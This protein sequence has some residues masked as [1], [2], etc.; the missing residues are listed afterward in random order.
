MAYEIGIGVIGMGWMGMVH[1]RSY[2]MVADRFADSGIQARL[3]ICADDVEDRAQKAKA[4]LGFAHYT[5]DWRQVIEHPEVDVV[6]IAS[7]N[8]LHLQM[9]QAAAAAGKHIFCEKP[10]GKTP[11]ETARIEQLARTAGV[12]TFVGFNYRWAPL[13]QYARQLIES[14]KLGTLTHYRGR[15]FSMYG[16]N[17]L[18]QLTWRFDYE[19]SGIGVLGDLMPHVV[20]MAHML[21]G[22]I[23]RVTSNRHTFIQERP[24][25]LAGKGTHF[26]TGSSE[27]PKGAVTNEDY[28]NALLEFE[29]GVQGTFESCRV[30]YGP[31]CEMAF[32]MNGT[33]GALSWNFERMNEL[34]LYLPESSDLHN[35]Y[36][37][38]VAGPQHPFHGNFNPGAGVGIGYEDLKVIE[39]HQFLK[40]VKEGKQGVPGFKE[41]LQLANV[42]AAMIRSWDSGLW[43]ENKPLEAI[44]QTI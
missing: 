17:P 19:K 24:L 32:E 20:D 5:T 39:A 12:L 15:F 18:G 44:E 3:V 22:P 23:R 14:G 13:V 27:D 1:G 40:S 42:Q 41:A 33:K 25:C 35:G 38:I 34:L 36:T 26:S 10:V 16:S 28:V 2:R 8:F 43:E 37:R 11:Q 29:N 4:T 9:V 21:A 31:K 6:N 7:P 30:I